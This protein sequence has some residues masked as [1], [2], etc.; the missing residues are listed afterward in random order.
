MKIDRR[1]FFA[2]LGTTAAISA[3]PSETLADALEHHMMETLDEQT[4]TN[5]L[6]VRRGAGFLFGGPTPS[7]STPAGIEKL[8]PMPEH[9]TLID[10]F[11]YRFA[12]ATHVLQSATDAMKKGENEEMILACLLHDVVLN[13]IKVDH[14]WW[15]AQLLEPY[16]SAKVSWGI[17][18]H[19][20]LRFFP[21]SSVG[22]EYPE[23]YRRIFGKDY[24]PPPYIR[25]TYD[26][27]RNHKW[28]MEARMIT[29]HDIYAFDPNMK[30]SLDPF[31]DIIGRHFKQPK[32]GL[33]Y[34]NSPVAHMWRTLIFPDMPL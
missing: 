21:D 3:M 23:L 27:A 4:T 9:P 13:L 32:E 1:A 2:T 30:V 26:Y 7:G 6:K 31:I 11:K 15:G 16:V 33:G 14:G 28:Y 5:D 24:E 8:E 29:V 20:A 34:D 18:Y 10:F 25:R 22:Y 12:P 17:R 19:Q